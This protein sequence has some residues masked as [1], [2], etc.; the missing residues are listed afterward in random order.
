[1]ARVTDADVRACTGFATEG[2]P[3]SAIGV[4]TEIVTDF[5]AI[6]DTTLS[7]AKLTNIELYLASHFFY[8]SVRG[9]PLAAEELGD[10]KERYHNIYSAGLKAT[11]FGQQ[12]MML[13][14]S[15]TLAKMSDRAE[16]PQRKDALF[17]VI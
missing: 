15:G 6:A 9:G 11:V 13:D 14:P 4:A 12:A 3:A 7:A 16:N 8:L 5:V 1:M 17:Q 2:D 10:A